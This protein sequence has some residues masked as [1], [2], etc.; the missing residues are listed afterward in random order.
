ML[1]LKYVKELSFE[2]TPNYDSLRKLFR[3]LL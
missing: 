3:D 2:E 1:Y